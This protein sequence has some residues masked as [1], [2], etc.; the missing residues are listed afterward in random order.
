MNATVGFISDTGDD[1][2]FLLQQY[3]EA[4]FGSI[5]DQGPEDR[6]VKVFF[7]F[8]DLVSLNMIFQKS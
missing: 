4:G 7:I 5:Q 2:D 3:Q 6:K 1:A 8:K